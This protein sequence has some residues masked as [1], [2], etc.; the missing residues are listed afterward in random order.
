MDPFP[1]CEQLRHQMV[2]HQ[3]RGRGIKDARVL[4]AFEKVPRHEFVR[5]SE[6]NRAYEDYPLPIGEGQ[7]ISQP[8]MVAL[9][10]HLL[11]LRGSEK[12]LEVGSGSG[13]QAAILAELAHWV[14]A[15]ERIPV[16]AQRSQETLERLHYTNVSVV[17]SDGSIGLREHAPFDAIVVSAAAPSVSVSLV[18]QL[19]EEGRLVVPVGGRFSQTL[20]LVENHEGQVL[21][22]DVCGCV[23]VPLVGRHGWSEDERA[24]DAEA[25]CR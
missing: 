5:T 7:T 17:T 24:N 13:Y 25:I 21:H 14:Y 18:D 1:D 10:T 15:V 8:Y 12:V 20:T 9:M 2:E 6:L 16:L 22:R 11:K 3:L 23:F 19:A 4:A